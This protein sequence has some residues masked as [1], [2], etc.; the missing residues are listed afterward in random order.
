[1]VCYPELSETAV[2]KKWTSL[3]QGFDELVKKG[4]AFVK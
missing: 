1:M 2:R 4:L 3:G